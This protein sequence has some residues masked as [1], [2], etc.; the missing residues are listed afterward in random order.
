MSSY[1]KRVLS[2]SLFSVY[3]K[4]RQNLHK[5]HINPLSDEEYNTHLFRWRSAPDAH[6]MYKYGF[7]VPSYDEIHQ[8]NEQTAMYN[9]LDVPV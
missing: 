3:H 2:I 9:R 6:R 4:E 1:R 8:Y 7:A 5:R